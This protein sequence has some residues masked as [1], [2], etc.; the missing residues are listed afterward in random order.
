MFGAEPFDIK[1]AAGYE[2]FQ[3]FRRLGR[4]GVAAG[5]AP[6]DLALAADSR[7]A[8]F[9]AGVG[10]LEGLGVFWALVGHHFNH[11]RDHVAGALYNHGVA[12]AHVFASDLVLVMEGR[13]GDDDAADRHRL[14]F[15]H[16]RQGAGAAYLNFDIVDHSHGLLCR[17]LVRHRPARRARHEP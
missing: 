17:E 6:G 7:A 15:G 8:A 3:L 16:W 2:M 4:A 11:L 10:H 1:G 9:R 12:N 13:V 14:Q 5:A